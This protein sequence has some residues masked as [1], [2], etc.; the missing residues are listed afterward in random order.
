MVA[1]FSICVARSNVKKLYGIYSCRGQIP[2]QISIEQRPVFVDQRS[3]YGDW[4]L[5][6]VIGKHHQQA[7]ATLVE[8]NSRLTLMANTLN[9]NFYF[10]HPYA[11]RERD[12]NEKTNGLICQYFP[13][14]HDFTK[15]TKQ[16]VEHVMD[17]TITAQRKALDLKHPMRCFLGLNH[18]LH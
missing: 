1:C 15:I 5:D 13:K 7:L 9:D 10:A 18:L 3:N 8:R 6:T 16:Q 4:E 14:K 12:L 17:N 11:S 2:G